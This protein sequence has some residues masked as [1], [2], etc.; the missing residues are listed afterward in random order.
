MDAPAAH[1][2]GYA[3]DAD[4][5]DQVVRAVGHTRHAGAAA[6]L[7]RATRAHAHDAELL[8]LTR[9]VRGGERR[10]TLLARAA[11]RLDVARV[12]EILAACPTPASRAELLACGDRYDQTAL[13]RACDPREEQHEEAALALVELLL[14][15]GADPLA[16]ARY[17][18]TGREFH[19][20]HRAA[21]WS[22]RLVQR[23]VQAG[24]PIDGDVADNSTLQQA[25]GA[26]TAVGVR[27]IPALVALGA[28][29]TLGTEVAEL[30]RK[31][32]EGAAP[33]DSDVTAA[34]TALVSVGC[35]LTQPY[36]RGNSPLEFAAGWGSAPVVRALLA[37]GVEATTRS[38]VNAVHHPGVVRLLL[39]AGARMEAQMI[40]YTLD[41]YPVTPLMHAARKACL[42]SVQ[43][44]LGAG[45]SL[46]RCNN[47]YGYTALMCS[48]HS[49]SNDAT[50]V[51]GVVE[52]LLAAGAAVNARDWRSSGC[53]GEGDTPLHHLAM[54]S[55]DKPWAVT[56]ARLLLASGADGRL[57]NDFGKT[58]A[59][60]VPKAARGGH[61]EL[62]R[63]LVAAARS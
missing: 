16:R 49:K 48:L 63:L 39:A 1:T 18:N 21:R 62:H 25:A 47:P 12:G 8:W 5:W 59:R 4:T 35:S 6:A 29:Q 13:F 3:P 22:A 26:C 57:K 32:A 37:A 20:I 52:A 44:L 53:G 60:A 9:A 30:A 24:A 40:I 27:M 34:F 31:P 23:L 46:T 42:E 10:E 61:S 45:A 56:A 2:A 54:H 15:A 7:M 38:L 19:P 36:S 33:S 50:A 51:L 55:H 17:S 43:L 28:R 58:P 11:R 41:D 14:G